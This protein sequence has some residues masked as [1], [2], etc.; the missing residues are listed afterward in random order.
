MSGH[1]TAESLSLYLD[2]T[3]PPAVRRQV[4]DHLD[5][6]P[7]CRQRLDGL[8]RVVAGIGRLP[9]AV[10]PDDLAA[11]VGREIDL[12]GRRSRWSRLIQGG[13]PGPFVGSPPLHILAL[14]LALGAIIYLFSFGV[15]MRRERPT[16]IVLPGAESVVIRQ[17][18]DKARSAV[19]GDEDE[20]L[21][22]LGGRFHRA[23]GIWVEEGLAGRLPDARVV[24]NSDATAIADP[25]VAELAALGAPLRLRVGEEVLEIAF[26][27]AGPVGD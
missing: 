11:R 14:V 12:R 21:H 7:A 25:E 22:M 4:Q 19:A 10:P 23:G 5:A 17:P 8:R 13:L 9:T 27:P 18:D 2:A 26:E 3:L 6:C 1:A 16:R 20:S 24:L 15:E